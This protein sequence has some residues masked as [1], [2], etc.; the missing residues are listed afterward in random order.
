MSWKHWERYVLKRFKADQSA[1]LLTVVQVDVIHNMA[2]LSLVGKHM[3]NTI[4]TAGKMFM[5]LAKAGVNI[6]VISQGASE[7]N[8]SCVVAE[9]KALFAMKAIHQCLLSL[10]AEEDAHSL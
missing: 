8:I 6:E 3:K 4:G 9:D 1:G 2:I 7:I 10:E 5:A